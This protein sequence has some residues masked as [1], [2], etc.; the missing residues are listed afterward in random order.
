MWLRWL[1]KMGFWKKCRLKLVFQKKY[2]VL[3]IRLILFSSYIPKIHIF[4]WNGKKNM[5]EWRFFFNIFNF[6]LKI[7]RL[8]LEIW[9]I[10]CIFFK[11]WGCVCLKM[12]LKY[13]LIFKKWKKICILRKKKGAKVLKNKKNTDY[14]C[15]T[16]K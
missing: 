16:A 7:Y 5:Y 9:K 15:K 1:E 14:F 11:F 10:I 4:F 8:F 6:F 13:R 2:V 12:R 3:L